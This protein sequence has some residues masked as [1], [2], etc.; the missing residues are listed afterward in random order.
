[1]K[2]Q[3]ATRHRTRTHHLQ[4]HRSSSNDDDSEWDASHLTEASDDNHLHRMNFEMWVSFPDQPEHA[5]HKYTNLQ[6]ATETIMPMPLEE[7][8]DW[9][10]SFP[11]LLKSIEEGWSSVRS[12]IVLLNTSFQLMDNFPPRHSKLGIGL[13]LEFGA[14]TWKPKM[15]AP[16][17][18]KN[19]YSITY[20]YQNGEQVRE[21]MCEKCIV[22]PHGQVRPVFQSRW[23]ALTFTHLTE[24]KKHAEDSKDPIAIH[25][26]D[27]Q[28]RGFFHGLTIMQEIWN[29]HGMWNCYAE[30]SGINSGRRMAILLWK[31]SQA[32][33][34]FVGTTTWQKL[35]PPPHRL[36][37]NSPLPPASEM[38]LP[39]LALD[40]MMEDSPSHTSFDRNDHF[41]GEPSVPWD[42][43]RTT[44]EDG[45][46]PDS[47]MPF[48]NDGSPHLGQMAATFANPAGVDL[49]FDQLHETGDH[50]HF[51]L[52]D[53]SEFD[54]TS[55]EDHTIEANLFEMHDPIKEEPN[56]SHAHYGQ[57]DH[58]PGSIHSPPISHD[59]PLARFDTKYHTVLQEQLSTDDPQQIQGHD[60][61]NEL[62]LVSENRIAQAHVDEHDEALRSALLAVSS[63]DEVVNS[64]LPII[65]HSPGHVRSPYFTPQ[66][67][68]TSHWESPL[69]FRPSLQTHH[70]FPEMEYQPAADDTF[71]LISHTHSLLAHEPCLQST[72]P[73]E[74]GYLNTN[75]QNVDA[76]APTSTRTR[77]EPDLSAY[78]GAELDMN[79]LNHPSAAPRSQI[80]GNS[81]QAD[82]LG[83][84]QA[85]GLFTSHGSDSPLQEQSSITNSLAPDFGTK[86]EADKGYAEVKMEGIDD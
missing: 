59:R 75:S 70:S 26:A 4:R 58:M 3:K 28:V 69:V 65:P 56:L 71:G 33:A 34:G 22:S 30:S 25:S 76:C 83:G 39:P 17:E 23:W 53:A 38:G 63:S 46:Y 43:F 54:I 24:I 74:N 2:Q 42:S 86:N 15:S 21:P 10:L 52:Q 37:T 1:M 9:R 57:L 29:C 81:L 14:Q 18:P 67:S 12:E 19:W 32:Q 64:Q 61:A 20:I 11:N 35:I 27:D 16:E 82:S 79:Q 31:F 85:L 36:A 8:V 7:L 51:G 49:N 77:S 41:L 66:R 6:T 47:F 55:Q 44:V 78:Q 73:G 84:G 48:K 40:T 62:G 45:V 60:P 68:L 50:N 13:E 5:L 72:F 80:Q